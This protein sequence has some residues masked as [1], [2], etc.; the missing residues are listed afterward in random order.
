MYINY[1]FVLSK[2]LFNLKS[3]DL[4]SELLSLQFISINIF[5][6]ATNFTLTHN[7]KKVKKKYKRKFRFT[8]F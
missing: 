8:F 3:N 1:F 5:Q 2:E 6:F 4:C 7:Y